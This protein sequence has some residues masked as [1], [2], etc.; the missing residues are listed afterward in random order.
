MTDE[1]LHAAIN[2]AI[3]FLNKA[4]DC[5]MK[6]HESALARICGCPESS[7]VKRSSM[8]LTRVLADL[9]QGR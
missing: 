4:K 6:F 5:K 8:D 3:R 2:E 9:R 7:A 1:T